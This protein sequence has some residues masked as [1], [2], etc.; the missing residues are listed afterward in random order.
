MRVMQIQINSIL[1][2]EKCLWGLCVC[3]CV[4]VYVCVPHPAHAVSSAEFGPR[5]S[6]GCGTCRAWHWDLRCRPCSTTAAQPAPRCSGTPAPVSASPDC[7]GRLTLEVQL[8]IF[9]QYQLIFCSFSL[10]VNCT[11]VYE[12]LR[13]EFL[14][15]SLASFSIFCP[16]KIFSLLLCRTEREEMLEMLKMC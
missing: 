15:W 2:A 13:K 14:G 5:C 11:L 8:M 12:K 7:R 4:C 1:I 10:L 9:L 6:W 16:A 3:V